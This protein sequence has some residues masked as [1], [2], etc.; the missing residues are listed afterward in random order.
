MRKQIKALAAALT[1]A[2]M[3]LNLGISAAAT[4]SPGEE[5]FQSTFA[6]EFSNPS[7]TTSI[8]YWIQDVT[9][10][11]EQIFEEIQ[12]IAE[13]GF[14]R[15]EII[16]KGNSGGE[17]GWGSPAWAEETE[18]I[19]DAAN[20][21]GIAV[22]YTIHNDSPVSVPDLDP[23]DEGASRFI[24]YGV[25]R[26]T[27]DN[28][29]DY[30]FWDAQE[31]SWVY[32]HTVPEPD[33][34]YSS[35]APELMAVT[36]AQTTQK[37]YTDTVEYY[38]A[39]HATLET[40]D[41]DALELDTSSMIAL[42]VGSEQTAQLVIP[43]DSEQDIAAL[44]NTYLFSFW[45]QS[46][47]SSMINHFTKEGTKAITDYWDQNIL[48]DEIRAH[49][50][51]NGGDLF[52]DSIE[53]TTNQIPWTEDILEQ[54][55]SKAGYD[56]TAY[57]PILINRYFS[58]SLL[59][60]DNT[61]RY[62]LSDNAQ[63]TIFLDYNEVLSQLFQQNH[64]QVLADWAKERGMTY[65]VQAYS[66]HDVGYFD[67][68]KVSSMDNLISEGESL[69]FMEQSA[70]YDSWR[71]IAGGS[72]MAG[73]QILSDELGA[74]F[75]IN[76][77]YDFTVDDLTQI[78]NQN[79][80]AGVNRFIL[81]G[82][83]SDR[84]TDA[85]PGSHAFGN[86]FTEPWDDR[87][88]VWEDIDLLTDYMNR[89]ELVTQKGTGK[90]DIAIFRNDKTIKSAY[91]DNDSLTDYGY[92]YEFVS[93]GLL[94]L[95]LAVVQDGILAP[96]SAAY[97]AL[98]LYEQ[99]TIDLG[100]IDHLQEYADAGLPIV[101]V[102]G[103]PNALTSYQNYADS[104]ASLQAKL[105]TL[106][107]SEHVYQ[108]AAADDLAAQLESI[109]VKPA[110]EYREPAKIMSVRRVDD[111]ESYYYL[112][113]Q[114]TESENTAIT[115]KGA[116]KPYLLDLWSGSIQPVAN[117]TADGGSVTLNVTLEAGDTAVVVLTD[118]NLTGID[119]DVH[120]VSG[121][122]DEYS[123]NND[124]ELVLRASQNGTYTTT[125][126]DGR[127]FSA[128]VTSAQDAISLTEG[129]WDVSV[130]SWTA[131]IQS[132]NPNDTTKTTYPFTLSG[133]NQ[134]PAWNACEG[135]ETAS[136]NAAYSTE[137][138]L[139]NWTESSGAY[140]KVGSYSDNMAITDLTVN[141]TLLEAQVNQTTQVIDLSPYLQPGKNQ[142]TIKLSSTL[143]S[144]VY[145]S[146]REYGLSQISLTPF[147]EQVVTAAE[148][149]ISAADRT[150]L[151]QV[152]AYAEKQY[153]SEEFENVIALVQDS[154][155][156]A[157]ENA[158]AVDAD[159]NAEQSAVDAAWKSLMTEIH[160]LG[161]IRGDKTNLSELIEL[162]KT[163]NAQIDKYTPATAAP[164]TT[165]LTE[166]QACLNDENAMQ[167]EV[168]EVETSLLEA[169]MNLRFRAD[170]SVLASVLA[171]ASVIDT[172]AYT[173]QSAAI[174]NS[175]NTAA[176]TVNDN[177]DATQAEVNDAADTLNAAIEGLTAISSPPANTAGTAIEGDSHLITAS[178]NAKTGE[179]ASI[180]VA[181][182]LLTLA[183]AGYILSQKKK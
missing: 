140:L 160:K 41:F 141:G 111:D 104:L 52:E 14:G 21:Y 181:V 162:A 26:I 102:G 119:T 156:K 73:K 66:G 167:Q 81:H 79:V 145:G 8:R 150:I 164:F 108:V 39:P 123:Y 48:T 176:K 86:I 54:F 95:D 71:Y 174:F 130:E 101:F 42:Q 163:F 15:I 44:T 24:T 131:D 77:T 94:D 85:W 88:P 16:N 35:S 47:G 92:T 93:P 46:G 128:Q 129:K 13:A 18:N 69:A 98:V 157:L 17:T 103:I 67:T 59:D 89:T 82:Y 23:D 135:L 116:G 97:Q 121:D 91:Y 33:Y 10:T 84:L 133:L 155:T 149:E 182:T 34:S 99:Q 105:D 170:K 5:K 29:S 180:A 134:L 9:T 122:A 136:G 20:T 55:Q 50:L 38:T 124:G 178:G 19:L 11:R 120:V 158:R 117:Y 137:F 161:F 169:M 4:I 107:A 63:E 22:D 83:N 70:G 171:K 151:A 147:T 154:F 32:N 53:Y 60:R 115:L 139:D 110:A 172:T 43:A 30:F 3:A 177:A 65:R 143:C 74:V 114:G 148:P 179:A 173:A 113:N 78:I 72:H 75:G 68:S 142:L 159:L 126:S 49:L 56:V 31:N 2:V 127:V 100:T 152:I 183:G 40:F 37:T 57:L 90:L 7:N 80:V 112:Y 58:G 87:Q 168:E 125:L 25:Q 27:Q 96:E 1:A 106:L 76:G 64:A 6:E 153:A 166:A 36:A 61:T 138:M 62:N 118:E 109:G 28:Y 144:V 165:A 132:D 45:S 12:M 175:A 146:T 51:A